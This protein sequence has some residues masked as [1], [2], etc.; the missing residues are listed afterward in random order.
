M[1]E[2]GPAASDDLVELFDLRPVEGAV[3]TW[4]GPTARGSRR[5]TLFGALVAAQALR[6]AQLS[7]AEDRTAH[8]LH[9]SF[10]STAV[11][12]P[13]VQFKIERVRDGRSVSLRRVDVSQGGKPFLTVTVS[14]QIDESGT[15]FEPSADV[16]APPGEGTLTVGT[17]NETGMMGDG[18][19]E[20]VDLPG[21]PPEQPTRSWVR[22]RQALPDDAA[23]HQCAFVV[24]VALRSNVPPML[25]ARLE[26]PHQI[27]AFDYQVWMQRSTRCDDWTHV[28]LRPGGNAGGRG[29]ALGVAHDRKGRQLGTLASEILFRPRQA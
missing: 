17:G 29:L 1:S 9:A 25:M 14:F 6:A 27:A 16:G 13:P 28:E 23:V 19:F 8:S 5:T 4:Q 26:G 12:G 10:F 24:A 7:A 18:A 20:I 21:S 22:C 15:D 2:G 3:D 11:H